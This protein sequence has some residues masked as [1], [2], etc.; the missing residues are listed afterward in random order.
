MWSTNTHHAQNNTP[1]VTHLIFRTSICGE[2]IIDAE[3]LD[4]TRFMDW[5]P[6]SATSTASGRAGKPKRRATKGDWSTYEC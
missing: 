4:M 1:N 3:L 6:I 5:E 2:S